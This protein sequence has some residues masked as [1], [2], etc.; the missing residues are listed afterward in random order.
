M[1]ARAAGPGGPRRLTRLSNRRDFRFWHL[2]DMTK[3]F[4]DVRFEDKADI[5]KCGG[6]VCNDPIRTLTISFAAVHGSR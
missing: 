4:G 2:A 1:I 3:L 5:R 6:N